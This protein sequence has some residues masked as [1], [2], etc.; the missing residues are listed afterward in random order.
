MKT[1]V[2]LALTALLPISAFAHDGH[3]SSH[4]HSLV[5]YLTEPL[6]V[7]PVVVIAVAAWYLWRRKKAS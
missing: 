1:K 2:T 5:H 3:G 7:I 4:A 6:H